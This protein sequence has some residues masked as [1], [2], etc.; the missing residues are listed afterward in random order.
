MGH[1]CSPRR[2]RTRL[3]RGTR[4]RAIGDTTPGRDISSRVGPKTNTSLQA[5]YTEMGVCDLCYPYHCCAV[6]R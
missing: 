1:N 4:G 3:Q 5:D 2:V 6:P